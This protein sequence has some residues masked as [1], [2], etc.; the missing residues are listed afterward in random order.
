MSIDNRI[1]V[2]AGARNAKPGHRNYAW[3]KYKCGDVFP[4]E[5][6]TRHQVFLAHGANV[7]IDEQYF[8]ED[9]E[10]ARWFWNEGYNER[11]FLLDEEEGLSAG[12]D[13]MALWIDGTLVAQ[14]RAPGAYGYIEEFEPEPLDMTKLPVDTLDTEEKR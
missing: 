1:S 12:Y 14:R 5:K 8:F 11:L 2:P 4:R 13:R 10:D 6:T 3:T 9:P 7:L